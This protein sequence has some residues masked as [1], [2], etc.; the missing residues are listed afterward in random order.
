MTVSVAS[1]GPGGR[2]FLTAHDTALAAA[3]DPF[4]QLWRGW[5]KVVGQG[6]GNMRRSSSVQTMCAHCR[7]GGI[8]AVPMTH[9]AISTDHRR[10]TGDSVGSA[11]RE[12]VGVVPVHCLVSVNLNPGEPT[13]RPPA[14]Q[15]L[16]HKAGHPRRHPARAVGAHQPDGRQ[17]DAPQKRTQQRGG[18]RLRVR[19][20]GTCSHN[21]LSHSAVTC[22]ACGH[23]QHM[24]R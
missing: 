17:A 1:C 8:P 23:Q 11:Q 9:V 4:Q 21:R 19:P 20:C 15:G 12:T 2:A 5:S 3:D 18:R 10:N 14:L 16:P 22:A 24:V 7:G 13:V 6:Q